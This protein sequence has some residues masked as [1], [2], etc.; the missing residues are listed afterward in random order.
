MIQ[1]GHADTFLE[2]LGR[3]QHVQSALGQSLVSAPC[4]WDE[5]QIIDSVLGTISGLEDRCILRVE[6]IDL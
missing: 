3:L 1:Y 4:C 2:Q 5:E 6:L